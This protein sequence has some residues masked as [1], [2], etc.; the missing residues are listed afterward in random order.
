MIPNS[1]RQWSGM[2]VLIAL[3]ATGSGH[4][5]PDSRI[6][7][8]PSRVHFEILTLGDGLFDSTVFSIAQDRK[9][10]MWFGT[11]SGGANRFDGYRVKAYLHEP[12]NPASLSS[13]AAGEVLAASDGS[14]LVGT[15][16]GGV[17]RYVEVEDRFE[18][19]TGDS[20]PARVQ[21]M[22]E[23]S[24]GRIWIGSASS[25][26]YV[27]DSPRSPARPVALAP[28]A[29]NSRI[30][31]LAENRSDGTVWVATSDGLV[32]LNGRSIAPAE[33]WHGH[34]RAL[35]HDGTTLWVGDSH[36]VYRLV[37]GSFEAVLGDTALVNAL[38]ISPA[39]NIMVG[40]QAGI[41]A[42]DENGRQVSPFGRAE[43]VVLP[44][45]NIRHFYFDAYEVGW[46]ATREAGVYQA[47][48]A[49]SGFD[50][51]ALESNLDTADTL[52]ELA[53]DD[54][55]IGSRSGLWRLQRDQGENRYRRIVGT[56]GLLINRLALHRGRV[57]V[58]H[59]EGIL[60]F[61]PGTEQI[62]AT[63]EF[64][65][66]ADRMVTTLI[67]RRDGGVDVGTWSDGLYRFGP[68]GELRHYVRGGELA[69]PGVAISDI[70]PDENDGVWLGTWN[71][72]ISFIGNDGQVRQVSLADLGIEGHVHD[73]LK[74][75]DQLWVATSFGLV[76]FDPETG[77]SQRLTLI[78]EFPNTAVQRLAAGPGRIWASTTRGIVAIDQRDGSITRFGTADGLVVQEFFARSGDVGRSGRIYFGGLGGLVSFLPEQVSPKQKPPGAAI[79]SA[80]VDDVSVAVSET[81]V[82]EPG[83][84]NLRLRYVAADYRSP[85]ANRFRWRLIGRDNA[86][87][88][89]SP[90][91]ELL[92]AGL[93]PGKYRFELQA[94]NAN[95]LWNLDAASLSVLVKPSWWQTA[96]G[97]TLGVLG[98]LVLAYLWSY[99]NT[100]RIR[101]RNREL[102]DEVNRQTGAL[103]EANQSLA[104]AASTDHLT[105][106][107]NR[108]GFL[109][110]VERQEASE[111]RYF[112]V[113]DADNFKRFN[114]QYGHDVGDRVLKHVARVL[115][116]AS[117]GDTLVA[118]WGG[119]EFIVHFRADSQEEAVA[120][121]ESLRREVEQGPHE[122]G[123]Q[124]PTITV[125]IG[126]ARMRGDE[127]S[128]SVINRA[129]ARLL[130]GKAEGKNRVVSAG[131]GM[132]NR[133]A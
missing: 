19:L 131:E 85:Q 129:D 86:W 64:A 117:P 69:I 114:D 87:S 70:E 32:D 50:G 2:M 58:G 35:L 8:D 88:D 96:W 43:A 23:D 17:N 48:P 92:M 99:W 5:A 75:D 82:L 108:R 22:F 115:G 118:R 77:A 90:D 16:G 13:S 3:G 101:A 72:G 51:F 45:R 33:G 68:D 52:L 6:W 1:L 122:L 36:A 62:S 78:R 42:V 89:S 74:F 44:D 93:A 130:R 84:S 91:R 98:L 67:S 37:G 46:I 59:G 14:L 26:L 106:L 121:A 20:G 116:Q 21:V 60:A 49:A 38:A 107:L 66:L 24:Q 124:I 123:D 27:M 53:P 95:G 34:P 120:A 28:V 132:V 100:S 112:A 9:G 133:R 111:S 18:R 125:T 79:V 105:G 11:A 57:L 55:L 110:Q 40:T 127:T 126:L 61:D 113:V 56:E 65:A 109:D 128:M 83:A 119:E 81:I 102:I 41:L 71:A 39:G 29:G 25:G 10:L 73:L 94:A 54:L 104:R 47:L 76:R 4:A 15:W 80:R 31:S 30:W 63:P 103:R 12:G 7:A 97:R